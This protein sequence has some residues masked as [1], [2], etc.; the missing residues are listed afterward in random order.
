MPNSAACLIELNA[1]PPALAGP[2]TLR[3]APATTQRENLAVQR[4]YDLGHVRLE[5]RGATKP[6]R[7]ALRRERRD[8]FRLEQV[9]PTRSRCLVKR[10]KPRRSDLLPP[11]PSRSREPQRPYQ[12]SGPRSEFPSSW[13]REQRLA[14]RPQR[15]HRVAPRSSTPVR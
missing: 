14:D 8:Q 3:L 13:I 6:R 15:A 10:P 1:S 7:V 2:I 5:L 9:R 12:R 4:S 11:H